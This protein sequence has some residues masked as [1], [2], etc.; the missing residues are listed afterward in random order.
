MTTEFHIR[1]IFEADLPAVL[2][3][4]RQCEDFLALGP[5]PKASM[6]MVLADM[7]LSRD[8]NGIFCG[9]FDPHER[10]MGILDYV[11]AGFCSAPEDA[12]IE[13]LMIAQ[14]Y[15]NSGL[16]AAVAT[17]LE[18]QV[19]ANPVVRNI[20]AGVQINNPGGI[21]FWTRMGYRIVSEPKHHP[22]QTIA[23]DLL[24]ELHQGE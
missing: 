9:I 3:V 14:P 6:D 15:R 24:K 12:F 21:R 7:Q 13:L 17:W 1:P 20:R 5:R 2:G 18:Q 22:D 4:Y 16:G 23:V 19:S 8:Q 10:L 11:P